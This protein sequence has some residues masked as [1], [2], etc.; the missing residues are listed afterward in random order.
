MVMAPGS[1]G[2]SGSRPHAYPT[3]ALPFRRGQW[4][5][6]TVRTAWRWSRCTWVPYSS[7]CRCQPQSSSWSAGPCRYRTPCTTPCPLVFPS[8][9][10]QASFWRRW[11]SCS[12]VSSAAEPL[13]IKSART[14]DRER[15]R[16]RALSLDRLIR[17]R[18][19]SSPRQCLKQVC[20]AR[21]PL[22]SDSLAP[23]LGAA[24]HIDHALQDRSS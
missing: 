12:L 24:F 9:G 3:A 19:R 15:L 6:S 11:S 7:P 14:A 5:D 10:I 16:A 2:H 13:Q 18:H 20:S 4:L 1:G 23:A 21:V 17:E 8:C 22:E